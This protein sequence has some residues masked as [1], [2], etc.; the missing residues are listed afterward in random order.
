MSIFATA[1]GNA[2]RDAEVKAAGSSTVV[3]FSIASNRKLKGQD[4]TTFINCSWFGQRAE[5]MA[6]YITRGGKYLVVGEV[7]QREYNGKQYLEM[8]VSNLEFAG[9]K[10]DGAATSATPAASGNGFDEATYGNKP[11]DDFGF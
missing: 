9:G 3:K 8:D 4:Q 5:K 10:R 7:S 2:T 1:L 6:Q 11:E